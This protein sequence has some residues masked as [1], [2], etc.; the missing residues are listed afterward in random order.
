MKKTLLLL[1]LP[2]LCHAQAPMLLSEA[3]PASVSVSADR[4]TRIDRV[5]Q[6]YVDQGKQAGIIALVVRN[7]K[8]VYHKAF[9]MDN[10]AAK[11]P[12]KRD[13][14]FRIAS[15]TKAITTVAAMML[16]EEGRFLLDEPVSKY[17]PAFKNPTVLSTF[18]EADSSYT[19]K[20]ASR[21]ITIRQLMTHT[22]GISY[23]SI[24]TKEANAIY[25][26]AGIP[27]GIGTPMNSLSV[28]IP[29]LAKLPLMH[30]PG[31]KW[32]YSLST[33]VLGYLVEV[34]SGQPLDQFFRTRIF[35]P[36]GMNDTY[37]YLPAA[38]QNRLATL[39]TENQAKQVIPSP[40]Q[41]GVSPDYPKQAGT[42]FSGGAGLS[43]TAVDYAMFLQMVLNGGTYN[44][45]QLL[46]PATVRLMLQNQIGALNVGDS[47]FGL[48][49]G[50]ATPASA[51]RLPVS[52]GS[53]SW[54]G[55]FGTDYWADPQ[56]GII[57]MVI[58]QKVPNSYG[59]LN[60][61][62]KVLVYQALT[63]LK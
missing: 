22:S 57:G 42:Y 55:F 17:I 44:G 27:S 20:P 24:G 49:F 34:V 60:D 63:G 62:F 39:F 45:K 10:P 48:G 32:T 38:K 54:G 50:I 19:T 18:N 5:L 3:A 33:D 61:K 2:A 59:D 30:N 1:L 28:S 11:T 58:T 7:G 4:L 43:S 23:T 53:F 36:L 51:A 40:I 6:E 29:A 9:G 35:E 41:G 31:E 46:G 37:F 56:Q 13:A 26:K 47:K 14:I 21:E 52:V 12:L 25:A 15:Q 16:F 8:I